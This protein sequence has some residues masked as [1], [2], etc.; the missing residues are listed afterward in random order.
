MNHHLL[1]ASALLALSTLAS[2]AFDACLHTFPD[3]TP[4]RLIGSAPSQARELCFSTFA[5]LHS[6]QSKTPVYVAERLSRDSLL[7][8]A[9]EER[10]NRFYEE[11]RV[12]SQERARLSDY[13]GS[14]FDRGH[15]APAANMPTPEAMAQSFSLSNMV[16]QAPHNNR[17]PWSRKVEEATRQ[18]VRRA[19]G[20]VFVFTGPVFANKPIM[21]I[22]DGR[23]WVPSH[24][25]KLVYDPAAQRAWAYWIENLDS[26]DVR[27]PISY[28]ELV[29]RVG[30]D[31]LPGVKLQARSVS[32]PPSP[33]VATR[34]RG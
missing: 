31:F 11:A 32:L 8:A 23:V 1:L 4:P 27:A 9:D 17:G 5:V 14:G 33:A 12:P 13:K 22:G 29:R 19:R 6:G 30:I 18:Y 16:P 21:T 26:A 28:E 10:S 2:A 3:N 25:Y 15:M 7:D 24:L 34:G 20:D